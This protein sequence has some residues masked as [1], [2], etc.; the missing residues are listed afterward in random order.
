MIQAREDKIKILES[1]IDSLK[2]KAKQ[3]DNIALSGVKSLI[4]FNGFNEK[5]HAR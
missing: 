3:Y 2:S 1:E 4:L 5:G